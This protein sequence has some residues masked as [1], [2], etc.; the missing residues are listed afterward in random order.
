MVM[1][2][3]GTCVKYFLNFLRSNSSGL[4]VQKICLQSP[5]DVLQ[6]PVDVLR[7]CKKTS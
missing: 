2:L 7:N 3:N 5:V 1:L 4:R 6:S